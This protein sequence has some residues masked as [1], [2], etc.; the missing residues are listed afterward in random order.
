MTTL[1]SVRNYA[2][3][4]VGRAS[5]FYHCTQSGGSSLPSGIHNS[6]D[7]GR[8]NCCYK[9]SIDESDVKTKEK[10][11]YSCI[12]KL[13]KEK[14]REATEKK[15]PRHSVFSRIFNVLLLLVFCRCICAST[16]QST[17]LCGKCS[18][19]RSSILQRMHL[20]WRPQLHVCAMWI[21][22]DDGDN[23]NKSNN[24]EKLENVSV[25][26]AIVF[27]FATATG[28]TEQSSSERVKVVRKHYHV[29][30]AQ[31]CRRVSQNL[32]LRSQSCNFIFGNCRMNLS[33]AHSRPPPHTSYSPH[34]IHKQCFAIIKNHF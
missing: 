21:W 13:H 4:L 8:N 7:S 20:N 22:T 11:E 28:E 15:P 29:L 30:S 23:D 34:H 10:N 6:N 31:R 26:V 12:L 3:M 2:M 32:I 33:Y 1:A 27:P 14:G 18:C 9:K 17:L 25:S 24:N 19:G 5:I 16:L